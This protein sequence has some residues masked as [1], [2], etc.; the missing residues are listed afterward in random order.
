MRRGH[1]ERVNGYST[2][3]WGWGGEDDDMHA[4]IVARELRLD[5]PPSA[6][7]RYKMLKHK[8]QELNPVR[9]KVLERAN[10]RMDFDGLNNVQYTLLNT[11]VYHL[12]THFL[13]AV[14]EQN[15]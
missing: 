15:L 11:T 9:M 2:E 8:H 5:R 14:G 10:Q 6:V 1:F 4:R 12:F 3:Y 13:I 7:A